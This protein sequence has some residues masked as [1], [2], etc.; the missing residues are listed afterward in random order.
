M[1]TEVLIKARYES[2]SNKPD[3]LQGLSAEQPLL[4]SMNIS[5]ASSSSSL[6]QNNSLCLPGL[7]QT[8]ACQDFLQAAQPGAARTKKEELGSHSE[9]DLDFSQRLCSRRAEEDEIPSNGASK[10]QQ[11]QRIW[12]PRRNNQSSLT[13]GR[14]QGG[15]ALLVL[16]TN[17]TLN[18]P[19]TPHLAPSQYFIPPIPSVLLLTLKFEGFAP[20]HL[21]SCRKQ[22]FQ[23]S[24]P[25]CCPASERGDPKNS[26]LSFQS[27]INTKLLDCS[28]SKLEILWTHRFWKVFGKFL[29]V[30]LFSW[31]LKYRGNF[32]HGFD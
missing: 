16:S 15:F 25:V 17:S 26:V 10:K 8:S 12:I 32:G 4:T 27:R 24:H 1:G 22:T 5:L 11:I 21:L 7:L 19:R 3:P 2:G 14:T 6:L 9:L 23:S 13:L 31:W 20:N 29:N 18:L 30:S 28:P